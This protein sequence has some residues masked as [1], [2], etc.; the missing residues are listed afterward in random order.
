M[1]TPVVRRKSLLERLA[2]QQ[3]LSPGLLLRVL[4]ASPHVLDPLLV[5]SPGEVDQ[6]FHEGHSFARCKSR[7]SDNCVLRFE[8]SY[9]SYQLNQSDSTTDL[10]S[11]GE[12]IEAPLHD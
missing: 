2:D 3:G 4:I 6:L 9:C 7:H 10:S 1:F 12:W 8:R 5:A 11:V